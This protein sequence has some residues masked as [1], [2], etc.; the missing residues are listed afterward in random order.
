M[1][2]EKENNIGKNIKRT[3]A[4]VLVGINMMVP[5]AGTAAAYPQSADAD[6]HDYG[7]R[8]ESPQG[9]CRDAGGG[10]LHPQALCHGPAVGQ[11]R[12]AAVVVC[13]FATSCPGFSF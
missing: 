6:H 1:S 3:M 2:M 10:R 11:R 13:L 4:G 8:G 12:A 5:G 9:L 7:Q